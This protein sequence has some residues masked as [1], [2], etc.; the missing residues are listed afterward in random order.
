MLSKYPVYDPMVA[1]R[2]L[3]GEAV[4]VHSRTRRLHVLDEVGTFIWE[5][6]SDGDRTV[7]QAV[8]AV[9]GE[10]EVDAETAHRDIREFLESLLAEDLV[11]LQDQPAT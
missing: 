2:T 4:I 10:F 8:E 11:R 6:F 5:A 1:C 3:D 7:G 9:C